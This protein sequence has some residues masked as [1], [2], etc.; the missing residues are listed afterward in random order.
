M[1]TSTNSDSGPSTAPQH[2][3]QEETT[4]RG[5]KVANSQAYP[6]IRNWS[7]KA[8]GVLLF[9]AA[10]VL[11]LSAQT[12]TTLASFDGGAGTVRRNTA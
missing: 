5:K 2:A 11:A 8:C 12:F 10:T 4:G 7:G 9:W 3:R 1:H 6:V